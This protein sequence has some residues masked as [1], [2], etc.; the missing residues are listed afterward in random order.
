MGVVSGVGG[1]D[2]AGELGAGF[3]AVVGSVVAAAPGV[4][5]STGAGVMSAGAGLAVVMSAGA[6]LG[7]TVEVLTSASS[8][9]GET[10]ASLTVDCGAG[11]GAGSVLPAEGEDGLKLSPSVTE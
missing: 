10:V 4:V 5:F 6:V 11:V 3:S 2:G 1:T 9:V 7:E 8:A